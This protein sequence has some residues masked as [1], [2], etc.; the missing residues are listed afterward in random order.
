MPTVTADDIADI[1]AAV[2]RRRQAIDPLL[3][4]P[5]APAGGCGAELAVTSPDGRLTAIG[6]CEHWRDAPGSLELT[7][8][9]AGRFLLTVQTAGPDAAGAL[10]QLLSRWHAHLAA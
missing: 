2:A 5:G 4:A 7:W 6:S 8:G 10:D 9:A 3:P 1:T